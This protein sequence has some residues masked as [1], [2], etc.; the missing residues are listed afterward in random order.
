[1]VANPANPYLAAE[2]AWDPGETPSTAVEV[3]EERA[4]SILTR[5]ESPDV[6]FRWSLNPYRGCYHGCWYCY[7][8]PRHQFLGLGA[9]TDFE[10]KLVVKPDAPAL[11]EAELRDRRWL[12]EL[13]ALS[14]DTDCYQPIEARYGLTRSC[15]E[16]CRRFRNPVGVVTKSRMVTR[17]AGLLAAL[18]REAYAAVHVSLSFVD[19]AMARVVEPGASLPSQRLAAIRALAD[20][21]VPVGVLVAPVI[22][23]LNDDQL[24][25][26]LEAAAAAGAQWAGMLLLRLPG[27]T[28]E[29]FVERL[30]RH[31]PDR[32]DK[33]I[34]R[35]RDVRGGE[36]LTDSRFG[37]R[38]RGVGPWWS[39]IRQVFDKTRRRLGLHGGPPQVPRPSPFRVPGKRQGR[40]W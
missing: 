31:L 20:E 10:N 30:R 7:A 27:A 2:V 29:V 6:P 24:Q 28:R 3:S 9:G 40:L 12:G 14:G 5:N 36:R 21:G 34:A 1:M 11:L 4:S 25:A 19:D 26:T 33:V 16:V 23:G 39:L 32:A 37:R 22:P 38:H 8:R 35:I 18:S 15:L 13:I 17:D